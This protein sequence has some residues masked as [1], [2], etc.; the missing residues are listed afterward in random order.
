MARQ[1]PREQSCWLAC[2]WLLCFKAYPYYSV[3]LGKSFCTGYPN[4]ILRLP[5][6]YKSIIFL[7]VPI[8]LVPVVPYL[9]KFSTPPASV[10]DN[11]LFFSGT[12][13]LSG[14][15]PQFSSVPYSLSV[16][17]VSNSIQL[18]TRSSLHSTTLS[19]VAYQS[20]Q[21]LR[22]FHA[23]SQFFSVITVVVCRISPLYAQAARCAPMKSV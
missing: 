7:I 4:V 17:C 8:F 10:S 16:G 19:L 3:T 5:N 22:E 12:K 2:S 13:T 9:I 15:N 18:L 20:S 21:R 11:L 23:F 14:E 6:R 1:I